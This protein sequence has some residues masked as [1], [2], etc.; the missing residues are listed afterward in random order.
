MTTKLKPQS[1]GA[2]MVKTALG[3]ACAVLA[4]I[5]AAAVSL[6][7]PALHGTP[8]A[9]NFAIVALLTLSFGM[10]VGLTASASTCVVFMYWILTPAWVVN[11]S[12]LERMT[13]MLAVGLFI[14]WM[15]NRQRST[16]AAG[17]AGDAA[18]A[19]GSADA[20]RE[21]GGDGAAERDGCDEINNP[22]E[23]VTNLLYLS[24]LDPALSAETSG[25]LAEADRELRRLAGICAAHADVR[26]AASEERA[27]GGGGGGAQRGGDV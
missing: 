3:Y 6:H 1:R 17:D 10:G 23:S 27:G 4:P 24:A 9:L 5:A 2:R 18:R 26:A 19:A 16:E 7:S 8:M 12:A 13:V 20:Q 14:T 25:Y 21:A 15:C 11:A 22:L